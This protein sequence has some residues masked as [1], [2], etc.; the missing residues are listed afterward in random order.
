MV[1]SADV[2]IR[3]QGKAKAEAEPIDLLLSHR[4]F[5]QH[6]VIK[7]TPQRRLVCGSFTA[8]A[9][10]EYLLVKNL[11]V[12][13]HQVVLGGFLFLA[14]LALALYCVFFVL[15]LGLRRLEHLS[16]QFFHLFLY[17]DNFFFK[18]LL[19]GLIPFGY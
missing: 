10:R 18:I 19:L 12:L 17:G 9:R 2:E 4:G 6:L 16:E 5:V 11:V 14:L 13:K 3:H 15:K 7:T 1:L 8:H